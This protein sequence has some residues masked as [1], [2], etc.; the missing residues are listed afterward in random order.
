MMGLYLVLLLLPDQARQL[1][2]LRLAQARAS[3]QSRLL[4]LALHRP[5]P[6]RA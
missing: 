1:H 3:G 6:A 4:V 2:Q 5:R